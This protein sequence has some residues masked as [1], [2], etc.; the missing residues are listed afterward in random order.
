VGY[1]FGLLSA[2]LFGANGSVAKLVIQAGIDPAQLTFFRCLGAALLAGAVVLARDRSGL[3]VSG[4]TLLGCALLGVVGIAATQWLFAVAIER[5]PVGITLLIQYFAVP[6]VAVVA[7]LALKEHVRPRLWVAIALVIAGMA[8]VAQVGGAPLDALGVAAAAGAAVAL[9]AYFL[10][11]ER[12][13]AAAPPLVI[14]FW[15]MLFAALLWAVPSGWWRVSPAA[16]GA[17]LPVDPGVPIPLWAGLLWVIAL[18]SFASYALS[19]L[20]I[21]RLGATRAGILA[22]AEVVFAFAVAWLWLGETLTAPQT[23]GAGIV[24]AGILVAQSA[25]PRQTTAIDADLALVTEG[26]VGGRS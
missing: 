14:A 15:S 11:G 13:V 24:L 6:I 7:W 12:G 19:Y 17:P 9:A 4:R 16:L 8:V 2:L 18:G 20:A 5:L 21:R 3:R 23:I 1:V 26:G 22:A 10:L 25:R